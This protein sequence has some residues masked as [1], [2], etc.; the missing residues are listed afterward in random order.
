M[1]NIVNGRPLPVINTAEALPILP[2]KKERD[3][4]R[5]IWQN[6]SSGINWQGLFKN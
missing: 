4:E 6:F 2:A 1:Q 3:G 5:P